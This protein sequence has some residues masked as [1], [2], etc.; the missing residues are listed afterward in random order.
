MTFCS[1][2]WGPGADDEGPREGG[3]A[4]PSAETQRGV[5]GE[6]AS[7]RS[8]P[9]PPRDSLATRAENVTNT[10]VLR[11]V[12]YRSEEEGRNGKRVISDIRAFELP[13]WKNKD[14]QLQKYNCIIRI[15]GI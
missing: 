11:C 8:D 15:I 10:T 2:C 4:A 14:D 12:R 1:G 9:I 7:L 13:S 6:Y 5:I 3:R